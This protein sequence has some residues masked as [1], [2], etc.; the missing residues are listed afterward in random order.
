MFQSLV[1]RR[2][3]DITVGEL[4][5]GIRK[6]GDDNHLRGLIDKKVGGG[7]GYHYKEDGS[8]FIN[9]K[10]P[11]ATGDD[12]KTNFENVQAYWCTFIIGGGG[13]GENKDKAEEKKETN[14]VLTA[15]EKKENDRISGIIA[16]NTTAHD[17]GE[18]GVIKIKHKTYLYWDD[19]SLSFN[20]AGFL[21]RDEFSATFDYGAAWAQGLRSLYNNEADY[22]KV[23]AEVAE[24]LSGSPA[25]DDVTVSIYSK[26]AGGYI[27]VSNY[28]I[29]CSTSVSR[30][31]GSF[32][33][34]M[35]SVNI[36]DLRTG[37]VFVRTDEKFTGGTFTSTNI[38]RVSEE[39]ERVSGVE[40][41]FQRNDL[42]YIKFERLGVEDNRASTGVAVDTLT[43]HPDKGYVYDMIGFISMV[44]SSKNPQNNTY[45]VTISGDDFRKILSEDMATST[46]TVIRNIAT[47]G[48]TVD[49]GS[50][51]GRLFKELRE[52]REKLDEI[53]GRENNPKEGDS[54]AKKMLQEDERRVDR[55]I[56]NEAG[57][58]VGIISRRSYL[59]ARN[60]AGIS[61]LAAFGTSLTHLPSFHTIV[62]FYL[63]FFAMV[64]CLPHVGGDGENTS[65][66][67]AFG[68]PFPEGFYSREATTEGG[69]P[70]IANKSFILS[71][72]VMESVIIRAQAWLT[73]LERR[74]IWRIVKLMIDN[75]TANRKIINTNFNR[76]QASAEGI[77]G[78]FISP[79]FVESY[80]DVYKKNI[81]LVYRKPP[82]DASGY[83]TAL[84]G[85]KEQGKSVDWS[86]FK[87]LLDKSKDRNGMTLT[88]RRQDVVNDNLSWEKEVYSWYRLEPLAWQAAVNNLGLS[89]AL[90]ANLEVI[91]DEY[92][93]LCG[94]RVLAVQYPYIPSVYGDN[95][96]E[97]RV[98][99]N[100]VKRQ[101]VSDMIYLVE[102]HQ[103]L[104]FSRRGVIT[105]HG[106]RR[107]K[108]GTFIYYELTGE[109]Y[110]VTSVSNS[111][112]K[113]NGLE[114]VTV[115]NVER[116]LVADYIDLYFR[117]I[118]MEDVKRSVMD[119]VDEDTFA[120]I[121]S[122][123]NFLID[124]VR[125][126]RRI[127]E[128]LVKR[129]QMGA[130]GQDIPLSDTFNPIDRELG[131]PLTF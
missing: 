130:G 112:T 29:S 77:I 106:D 124:H 21:L 26:S 12:I 98:S 39:E 108:I 37:G 63:S 125:V 64:P 71:A 96:D 8:N 65:E 2:R 88:V 7:N 58:M 73:D 79:K 70:E 109:V 19:L 53:T 13:K 35:A 80:C 27:D 104:P 117:I 97:N 16:A 40:L 22:A 48:S 24:V 102:S 89:G 69:E 81:T 116:G 123:N 101:L 56:E 15:D 92:T 129:G 30:R 31:S 110:Y 59:K 127:F 51:I 25:E 114:R 34:R 90:L 5:V 84:G 82:F 75:V 128:F 78:K 100:N 61:I 49:G 66:I 111:Y 3:D 105:I 54:A 99:E 9:E 28:V 85:D 121:S 94:N 44:S 11:F 57:A 50:S 126:D 72:D 60:L 33:L 47:G 87:G 118:D 10:D 131:I 115:L 120:D 119:D 43:S 103:Y 91:L 68:D 41:L 6:R 4:L 122:I 38:H 1:L 17:K 86:A 18:F 93:I 20:V 23:N 76:Q 95:D 74:G 42:V 55:A 62:R 52:V 45:D 46:Y 67:D 32:S 14:R 113:G 83:F 36:E 107:I